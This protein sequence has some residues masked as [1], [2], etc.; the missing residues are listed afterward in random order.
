[1]KQKAIINSMKL[2]LSSRSENEAFARSTVAAFA[3]QVN[4]TIDE[5]NDLKTAVS[6]AVT[7]CVVHAY[8]RTRASDEIQVTS[9]KLMRNKKIY[10]ECDLYDDAITVRIRDEGIGIVNIEK[11]LEP[12]YTTKPDEE[13][14]GMGFTVMQSF[15]DSLIVD[16]G[17]RGT[18]VTMQ[19]F[20]AQ[21]AKTKPTKEKRAVGDA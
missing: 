16:S 2:E 11:A 1:M 5:I 14:S 18:T 15:M 6:E 7:N 8:A 3:S 21:D 10:I 17:S 13:R 4:P 19:K 12:F 9:D 20:F